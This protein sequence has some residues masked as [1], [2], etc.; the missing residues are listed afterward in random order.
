MHSEHLSQRTFFGVSA[1]IFAVS[2]AGTI[3]WCTSMSALG[4]MP[5]PGGWT[6]S[7]A[8][9]RMC[10][11]TWTGSAASF[12]AMW[13]L[14]MVAMMSPS[15]APVLWRYRTALGRTGALRR[16]F[17]T[18]L[19]GAGYFFVWTGFGVAAFVSGVALASLEMQWPVLSRA[20]PFAAGGVVLGGGVLQ[21]SRWKAH[22]LACCRA[23]PGCGR[24]LPGSASA[25]WRYG[26]RHGLH[27]AYCCAGLTAI[28][29]AVGIMNLAAMALVTAAI[30]AE[31][32]APAGERVARAVGMVAGG[33]GVWLIVRAIGFA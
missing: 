32:L 29:L 11:Q 9:T 17:L 13:L 19:A 10:G 14:M 8:W 1:L 2:A 23:A 15:F 18:A 4:E 25:A 6:M 21:F 7:M 24:M 28:L 33:T 5:M 3:A 27:C 26:V 20:V 30:T 16:S 12:L 22:H 31:R